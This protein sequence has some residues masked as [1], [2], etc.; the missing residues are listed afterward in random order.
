MN[1]P[2][3]VFRKASSSEAI[4]SLGRSLPLTS[5][6]LNLNEFLGRLSRGTKRRG[7]DNSSLRFNGS[8][9]H[10]M[11][12]EQ[13]QRRT[14]MNWKKPEIREVSVGMEINMYACASRN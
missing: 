13:Q 1:G 14:F 3:S 9:D 8:C 2:R 12:R 6:N 11:Q 5:P 10:P 4:Q 7:T